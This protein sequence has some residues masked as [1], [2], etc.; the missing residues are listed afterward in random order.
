M[1]RHI[2]SVQIYGLLDPRTGTLRY[3][4]KANDAIAR[5]KS[6]LRDARR[7]QTPVYDW[8]KKLQAMG[9]L[10][11]IVVLAECQPEHWPEV[12]RTIIA[13]NQGLLNLAEGGNQPFCSL[14]IRKANGAKNKGLNVRKRKHI[15]KAFRHFHLAQNS[16]YISQEVKNKSL[17]ALER[18]TEI[19]RQCQVAGTMDL[20]E[21][22][23]AAMYHRISEK[24]I[25]S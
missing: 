7:R 19:V 2:G 10:P 18:F 15:I 11:E 12:E 14:E 9:L 13:Q 4:G 24:Q 6:H 22:R 5:F 1:G 20:L 3:V 17:A 16:K 21:S 25:G 8:I 23:L